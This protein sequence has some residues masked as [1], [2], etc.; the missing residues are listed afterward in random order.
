MQRSW[1]VTPDWLLALGISARPRICRYGKTWTNFF[2]W[3]LLAIRTVFIWSVYMT[4][5]SI[6][7]W[8]LTWRHQKCSDLKI[9]KVASREAIP[10][11]MQ[12][13]IAGSRL[14]RRSPVTC[15][16]STENSR[17]PLWLRWSARW[18]LRPSASRLW[19]A[20]A[21]ELLAGWPCVRGRRSKIRNNSTDPTQLL[22]LN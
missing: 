16:S 20:H 9:L 18:Q 11:C 12:S 17:T 6:P 8:F 7:L 21:P 3:L 4:F 14:V 10:S 19:C 22:S 1:P 2:S 5:S 15:C 13:T